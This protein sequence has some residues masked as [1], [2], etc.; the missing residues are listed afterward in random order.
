MIDEL[1]GQE[2]ETHM[3]D[4]INAITG[5]SLRVFRWNDRAPGLTR[6][7]LHALLSLTPCRS[8]APSRS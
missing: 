7:T 3:Q 4:L 8:S 6:A 2:V 1:F 5:V